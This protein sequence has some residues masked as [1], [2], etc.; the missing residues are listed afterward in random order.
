M[1]RRAELVADPALGN[2]RLQQRLLVQSWAGGSLDMPDPVA[3][4]LEKLTAAY[5]L[6]PPPADWPTV[7]HLGQLLLLPPADYSV[8]RE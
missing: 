8:T 5:E 3:R 4:W 6:H 7:Q 2:P 1:P